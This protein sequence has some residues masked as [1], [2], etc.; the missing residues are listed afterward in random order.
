MFNRLADGKDVLAAAQD[1]GELPSG[2]GL[3]PSPPGS[4][5]ESQINVA[6]H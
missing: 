3:R 4:P 1:S 2:A 6:G 5:P